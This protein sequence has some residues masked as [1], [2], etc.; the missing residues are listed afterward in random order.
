MQKCIATLSKNVYHVVNYNVRKTRN[1][2][3]QLFYADQTEFNNARRKSL[4]QFKYIKI[5]ELNHTNHHRVN[6]K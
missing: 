1:D 6:N 2:E 5:N 3:V 4:S